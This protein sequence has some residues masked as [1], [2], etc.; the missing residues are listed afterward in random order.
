MQQLESIY[1]SCAVVANLCVIVSQDR[2]K[3]IAVVSPTPAGLEAIAAKAGIGKPGISK[4]LEAMCQ[5]PQMQ[6]LVL[7]EMQKH[8]KK[9][10][11][12]SPE[13]LEGVVLSSEEWVPQTVS[14]PSC[15]PCHAVC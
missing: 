10:G 11:L 7:E 5:S 8:G 13:I 3:P 14:L 12:G 4:Q 15:C 2:A 9:N 6:T 1:R